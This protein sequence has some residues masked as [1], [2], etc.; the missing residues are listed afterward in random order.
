M[1]T[2][3]LDRPVAERV[4]DLLRRHPDDMQAFYAVM[5]LDQALDLQ[6]QDSKTCPVCNRTFAIAAYGK[7][8][9]YCSDKCRVKAHRRKTD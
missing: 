4:L 8:P 2:I 6:R 5:A 9:T 3:Q 7:T 1:I